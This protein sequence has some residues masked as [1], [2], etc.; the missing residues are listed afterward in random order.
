M[1]ER[2]LPGSWEW[3]RLGDILQFSRNGANLQQDKSGNGTPISR[4]E[5]ISYGIVDP[6][7]V[8]YT[9]ESDDKIIQKC[10]LIEGDLLF[11]HINSLEHIGKTAIYENNPPVLL[12]GINLL[13]LRPD[14]KIVNPKFLHI[15]F[16]KYRREKIFWSMANKAVNQASINQSRLNEIK[17]PLPPLP[18]QRHIVAILE[19]AEAVKRQ[20]QEADALTGALLQSVYFEMF[21]DPMRNEKGWIVE[22]FGNISKINMGQSP[23]GESYNRDGRGIALLNG[24]EEFGDKY[25]I[26]KQY[27][28]KPSKICDIGDILF[29]VRGATAGR[30]NWSDNN[31]C[32]GRGLA[33]IQGISKKTDTRF[34]YQFLLMNYEKFQKT[35]RGSTFINISRADLTDLKIPLPPLSLQQQFARI[36]EDVERIREK[37]V[38]SGKEIEGLCEGLMQRAF[39]GELVV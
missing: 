5:T 27:T 1:V 21:G 36:V 12:H 32:I 2:E 10:K 37:Q 4:I 7:K 38:A 35:G 29:C 3:K 24:P 39:A 31:Y 25:P 28:D 15:L 23:T 14:K 11:S 26:P 17:I 8:G 16:Q 19:Q 9:Q 20:R 34:L 6:T 22:K 18:V 13:L 33:A 30:M